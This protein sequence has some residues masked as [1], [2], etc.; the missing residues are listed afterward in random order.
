MR[1][2]KQATCCNS[3]KLTAR[4]KIAAAISPLKT[5]KELLGGVAGATALG[6]GLWWMTPF[7]VAQAGGMAFLIAIAGFL[8]GLVLS[9]SKRDRGLKDWSQFIPGHGGMLDRLDSLCFSAP[10]FF[11]LTRTWFA[12]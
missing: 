7:S 5:V 10:L 6:A 1:W 9:A 2:R 11:H 4:H 12:S 8:G 3:G